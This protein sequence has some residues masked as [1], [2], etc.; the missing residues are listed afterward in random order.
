MPRRRKLLPYVLLAPGLGW[1]L[2]FFAVPLYYM[3]RVS[4]QEGTIDT[5]FRF[6]WNFETYADAISNYSEQIVRS[7]AYAGVATMLALLIGYP[8]AYVIALRAGRW[9]NALLLLVIL[10]F[11]TT[12]L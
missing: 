1:L 11:F 2:L 4:L 12:Y 8:L 9:R 5:G 6:T 10:P 3:A 7:F